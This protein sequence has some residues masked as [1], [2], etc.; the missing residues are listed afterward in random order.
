M[1]PLSVIL[2]F[3]ATLHLAAPAVAQDLATRRAQYNTGP[4]LFQRGATDGK[5]AA[6]GLQPKWVA[7]GF[8]GA[9]LGVIPFGFAYGSAQQR[10]APRAPEETMRVLRSS[11]EKQYHYGYASGYERTALHERKRS[12]LVGGIAG[13]ATLATVYFA[14][15]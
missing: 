15:R 13:F 4:T 1:R 10:R 6:R 11:T 3:L 5:A 7:A 2:L 14:T 9:F 8:A 12:A